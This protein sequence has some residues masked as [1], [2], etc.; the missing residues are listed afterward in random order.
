M[1]AAPDL[2]ASYEHHAQRGRRSVRSHFA[3]D[4]HP[5]VG[6]E[7][8]PNPPPVARKTISM[9]TRP[10]P[11]K[12]GKKVLCNLTVKSKAH[13]ITTDHGCCDGTTFSGCSELLGQRRQAAGAPRR[14]R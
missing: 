2:T 5:R 13:S 3:V 11:P 12:L 7:S 9:N 14:R 6:R 8:L 1:Q 4:G 10:T